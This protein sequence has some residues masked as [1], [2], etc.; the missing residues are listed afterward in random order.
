MTIKFTDLRDITRSSDITKTIIGIYMGTKW[1]GSGPWLV[2]GACEVRNEEN[3]CRISAYLDYDITDPEHDSA[4]ALR[5]PLI[6]LEFIN[7]CDNYTHLKAY[8]DPNNERE[9]HVPNPGY[10]PT[11]LEDSYKCTDCEEPHIIVPEGYY[12]P[13]V[14]K[15]L[16]EKARGRK[17]GIRI[18]PVYKEP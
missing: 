16:Y 6:G 17:V 9:F 11:I 7:V 14:N 5:L 12:V 2:F 18:G 13:P 8:V 15:E 3:I 4:Y 10:N 1:E